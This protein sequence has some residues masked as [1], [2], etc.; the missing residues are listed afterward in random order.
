MSMSAA[1]EGRSE[2]NKTK[3]KFK[4]EGSG[5]ENASVGKLLRR[6]QEGA[7]KVIE[8]H[9]NSTIPQSRPSAE[10]LVNIA[11]ATRT[12][13]SIALRGGSREMLSLHAHSR[14]ALLLLDNT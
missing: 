6:Q 5:E 11:G 10:R 9:E 14:H 8:L 12:I 3:I 4:G 7:R 2:N 1:G 13:A